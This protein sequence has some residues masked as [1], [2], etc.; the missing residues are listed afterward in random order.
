MIVFVLRGSRVSNT[1]KVSFRDGIGRIC[2]LVRC[3]IR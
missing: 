3:G 1:F 2:L